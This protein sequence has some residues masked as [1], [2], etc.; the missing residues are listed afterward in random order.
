MT[1][2]QRL[3]AGCDRAPAP[4]QDFTFRVRCSTDLG[5]CRGPAFD[6]DLSPPTFDRDWR[7]HPRDGRTA[8]DR[9]RATSMSAAPARS[10]SRSPR[11]PVGRAGKL[12]LTA[13]RD[14]P[15]GPIR[16]A[17]RRRIGVAV[18][19]T[20]AGAG[21]EV[22]EAEEARRPPRRRSARRRRR[23]E[24]LR[25]QRR[26]EGQRRRRSTPRSSSSSAI[27]SSSTITQPVIGFASPGLNGLTPGS[28]AAFSASGAEPD[29]QAVGVRGDR[30]VAADE[31]AERAE[32]LPLGDLVPRCEDLRIRSASPSSYATGRG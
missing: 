6:A 32:D 9:C 27:A 26:G 18:A 2:A 19:G 21:E 15:D 3:R 12:L 20:G 14:S 23:A 31:E 4:P 24:L 22:Q 29:D 1:P 7:L 16:G 28:S 5:D 25:W 30:H 8:R 17:D 11:R 13:K 10:R